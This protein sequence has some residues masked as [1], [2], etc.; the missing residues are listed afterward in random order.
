MKL[1]PGKNVVINMVN[2]MYNGLNTYLDNNLNKEDDDF[3][4]YINKPEDNEEY[5]KQDNNEYNRKEK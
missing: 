3:S 1:K 5:E 4:K 2:D